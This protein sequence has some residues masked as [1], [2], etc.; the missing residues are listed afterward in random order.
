MTAM[1]PEEERDLMRRI[2]AGDRRAFE[3]VIS[4]YMTDIYRFALSISGDAAK[5]EDIA[6]ET[7]IRLWTRA[8]SWA[9]AG[10]VKHWLFTIAHRLCIDEL[11][12]RKSHQPLESVE[13]TLRDPAN[14]PHQALVEKQRAKAVREA[15]MALPERQRTAVMLVH[16]AGFSNPEAAS[17]MELSVDAVESLLARGRQGLRDRL[18]SRKALLLKEG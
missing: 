18:G 3:T 2:A 4:F 13:F 12:G 1:T 16:Y 9:A 8:D 10:R 17:V 5:A 7:C 14:D 6:Q 15:L 11:R